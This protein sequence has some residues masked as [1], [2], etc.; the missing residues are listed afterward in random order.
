MRFLV[1]YLVSCVFSIWGSWVV[2]ASSPSAHQ[3]ESSSGMIITE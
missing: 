3:H 1:V 2:D